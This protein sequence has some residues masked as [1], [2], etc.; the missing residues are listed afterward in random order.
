MTWQ[1]PASLTLVER[2][3]L[4]LLALRAKR[5]DAIFGAGI[6]L[7]L[8]GCGNGCLARDQVLPILERYLDDWFVLVEYQGG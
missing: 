6:A 5:G 4:Q 7:P 8:V 2:S 1:Q 3:V